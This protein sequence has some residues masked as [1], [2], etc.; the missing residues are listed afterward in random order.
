MPKY[1]YD[2]EQKSEAWDNLHVGLPTSSNFE[3]IIT[4][5]G[6]KSSQWK[7]YAHGLIGEKLLKRRT[8]TFSNEWMDR[9]TIM[10]IDA[11]S[12]YELQRDIDTVKIG[13]IT[14]DEHT[15]GCSPDRLVG[16]EGLLEI[17]CPKPNTFVGYVLEDTIQKDYY[18]QLQGQLFV[19]GR[20]WVDIMAFHPELTQLPV[21]VRMERDP[22]YLM[23]MEGLLKQFNEYL[24]D[25]LITIGNKLSLETSP[26][27][28]KRDM[29]EEPLS[30]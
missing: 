26:I 19:S 20:K 14:D 15:M 17:K 27:S 2:V 10:E 23:V 7:S 5:T 9:G 25:S 18:P 3:K 1:Y 21:I 11:V 16:E 4:P 29:I 30:E 13:F 24:V 6:K 12:E 28:K 8:D 22:T